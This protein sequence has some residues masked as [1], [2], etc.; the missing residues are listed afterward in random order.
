MSEANQLIEALKKASAEQE[1][2]PAFYELL[3]KSTVFVPGLRQEGQNG[4]APQL[5][6]KQWSQPAG[7]MA[8]PFFPDPEDLKKTLG[9]DEPYLALP[10]PDLFRLTRGTTLVLTCQD[11][12]AKAFKPDEVDMLLSSG[13]AQDP[14]AAALEKAVR[15][16]NNE[17][18][19]AFYRLFI[20][21]QVFVFGEPRTPDG[22]ALPPEEPTGPRPLRP[23]DKFV[24][25][26]IDHPQKEGERIIP[27][28]SSGELLQRAA[29]AG[30]LPPQTTFLGLPAV[31]LLKM[32]RG[33]GLPLVLN[34]GPMTYK[35]FHQDEIG[36]LLAQIKPP[37][38]EERQL[39]AGSR[40]SL[41]PPE[42]HPRE[43][44][45]ALL[46]FLP[47]LPGVKAAYLTTMRE[48]SAEAEPVLVIGLE[49]EEDMSEALQ[50]TA[51]LVARHAPK[52]QAVDF[53]EV[54]P[55]EKGLSQLLLT[56]VEPFYRR[57][58]DRQSGPAARPETLAEAGEV[59]E[60]PASP[61]GAPGFFGRLKRIFKG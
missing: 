8:I 1:A 11:G 7:F 18:K 25:A 15:E 48:D 24:I 26:T 6:F 17:T 52:G 23:D 45:E 40:V 58:Q 55:G 30:N 41:A 47:G 16:E 60:T 5:N 33:M 42:V 59:T 36:F 35:I 14:L 54:R 9:Q 46:D 51:P 4:A 56:K 50:K 37:N 57:G 61:D 21:S 53:T 3:M 2:R 12:L 19:A 34:L 20:N 22:E 13:L 49:T 38:Y 31:H 28:F 44:V 29:K 27:F 10:A 32:A 43:L 39:P